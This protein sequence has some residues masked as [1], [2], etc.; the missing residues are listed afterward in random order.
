[1]VVSCCC[2]GFGNPDEVVLVRVACVDAL[3][4]AS[5]V[6]VSLRVGFVETK[7]KPA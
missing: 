4:F 3:E 5:G 2:V 6:V 7:D 1:M